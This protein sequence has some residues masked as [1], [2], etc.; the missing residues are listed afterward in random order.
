MEWASAGFR[1]A[2]K[3]KKPDLLAGKREIT[4]FSTSFST[5]VENSGGG[6]RPL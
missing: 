4:G 1:P 2:K 6:E 3:A 5:G